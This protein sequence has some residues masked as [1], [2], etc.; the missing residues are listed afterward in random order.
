MKLK[1]SKPNAMLAIILLAAIS[2]FASCDKDETGDLPDQ[3]CLI[4]NMNDAWRVD[5]SGDKDS[6]IRQISFTYNADDCHQVCF[7]TPPAYPFFQFSFQLSSRNWI[8]DT[9]SGC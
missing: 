4:S 2:L 3:K 9:I 8:P 5:C 7:N 6:T 1:K